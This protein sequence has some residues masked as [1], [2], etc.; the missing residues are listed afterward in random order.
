MISD[1]ALLFIR[2]AESS[3]FKDAA[4][5]LGISQSAASKR[6]TRLEKEIGTAL[7]NRNARRISLTPAGRLVLDQCRA[8]CAAVA[9]AREVGAGDGATTAGTVQI[10][11]CSTLGAALMPDW[12]SKFLP[13]HPDLQLG[14]HFRDGDVD[15][16]GDGIDVAFVLADRLE[17]SSL[18]ARR[19]HTTQQVLVASPQYLRSHGIPRT[20]DDLSRHD[21]LGLGYASPHGGNWAFATAAGTREVP[22]RYSLKSNS[23]LALAAAA[24]LDAGILYVPE[25]HVRRELRAQRLQ[26][27]RIAGHQAFEWGLYAIHRERGANEKLKAIIDFVVDHVA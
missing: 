1:D 24:C 25:I 20:L 4:R 3:S 16:V 21:C 12:V 26:Q 19:L 11:I 10:A 7:V 17:S 18:I 2:V 13:R 22:I 9:A 6:I 27:I 15:V 14:V 23:Y 8:I 5:Q